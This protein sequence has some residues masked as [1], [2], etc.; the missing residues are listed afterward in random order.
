MRRGHTDSN[1]TELVGE[2]PLKPVTAPIMPIM[3]TKLAKT[4]YLH[5]SLSKKE[6]NYEKIMTNMK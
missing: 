6:V 2:R 4:N 1:G 3:G 5:F